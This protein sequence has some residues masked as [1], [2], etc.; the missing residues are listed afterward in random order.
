MLPSYS[1]C[2]FSSDNSRG[3]HLN[4]IIF[5]TFRVIEYSSTENKTASLYLNTTNHTTFDV[6]NRQ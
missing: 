6:Q 1:K 2:E 5:K 4:D 3:G